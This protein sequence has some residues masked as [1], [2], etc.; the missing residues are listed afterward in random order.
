MLLLSD[1][2]GVSGSSGADESGERGESALSA[3]A[4]HQ[5]SGGGTR[6]LTQRSAGQSGSERLQP[7]RAGALQTAVRR[8]APPPQE[9]GLQTGEVR[10][11]MGLCPY[12]YIYKCLSEL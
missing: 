10:G 6:P 12:N 4:A 8:R 1:A 5:G 11:M 2:G 3:G 7:Q 9:S